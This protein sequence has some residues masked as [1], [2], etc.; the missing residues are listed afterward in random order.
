MHKIKN[1]LYLVLLFLTISI[2]AWAIAVSYNDAVSVESAVSTR[3]ECRAVFVG[4]AADYDF[5]Q[6]GEWILYKGML[7][8]T[9]YEIRAMGARDADD[10]APE[11]GDIL[12]L[13]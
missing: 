13:Y 8:G 9:I 4:V 1:V 6:G 5:Y 11:A 7:A 10:S 3:D 12:F 2:S